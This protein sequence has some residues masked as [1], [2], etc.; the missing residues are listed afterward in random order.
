MEQGRT[1][2]V[3]RGSLYVFMAAVIQA[4]PHVLPCPSM[5]IL[6]TAPTSVGN[7]SVVV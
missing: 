4:G 5:N 3:A 1:P 6:E 7:Y 2:F